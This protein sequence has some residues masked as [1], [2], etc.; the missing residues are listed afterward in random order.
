MVR[1]GRL[2][3]S[4]FDSGLCLRTV[5]SVRVKLRRLDSDAKNTSTKLWCAFVTRLPQ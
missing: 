5:H 3:V 4:A 2:P 1:E